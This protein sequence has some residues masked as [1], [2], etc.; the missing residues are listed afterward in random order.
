MGTKMWFTNTVITQWLFSHFTQVTVITVFG[1]PNIHVTSL[2][3]EKLS[4]CGLPP[5]LTPDRVSVP[6]VLPL[7]RRDHLV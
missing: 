1:S 3:N 6:L 5:R 4:S 7:L 2:S